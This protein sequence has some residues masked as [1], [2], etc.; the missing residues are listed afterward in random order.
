VNFTGDFNLTPKWKLG[1]TTGYDF[2]NKDIS[3]T[4]LTIYRDLHCWEMSVNWIPFGARKSYNFAINVKSSTLKDL[5]LT[6]RRDWQ[7]RFR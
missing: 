5:K 7:D 6:R 4:S 1:Y 3:Y 2:S